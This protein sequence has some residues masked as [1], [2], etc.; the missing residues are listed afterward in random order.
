MFRAARAPEEQTS[1]FIASRDPAFRP[2][3]LEHGPDGALY[4]IDMQRDVIEHPDYIPARVREKLDIRA[5]QD[6]GRI[7]R[8]I[9]K[10]GLPKQ[11]QSLADLSSAQLVEL[12]SSSSPWHRTTAHKILFERRAADSLPLVL[13]DGLT[14]ESAA[15]RARSLW[16]V[17]ALGGKLE[18]VIDA[19]LSDPDPRV[20]QNGVLVAERHLPDRLAD[21]VVG[22]ADPHPQ[23]RFQ[24]ALSLDGV[25][26]ADG[27]QAEAK[28]WLIPQMLRR[29]W[30]SKWSRRAA[31][32]SIDSD[33]RQLLMDI[34]QSKQFQLQSDDPDT[35][36][37]IS[38]VADVAAATE[39]QDQEAFAR[40][41]RELSFADSQPEMV[42]ALMTGLE[43][44]WSR[45]SGGRLSKQQFASIANQ[46]AAGDID[47]FESQL[48]D[49]IALYEIDFPEPLTDLFVNAR[50][51][52]ADSQLEQL[53]RIAAIEILARDANQESFDLLI[54]LLSSP[55]PTDVQKVAIQS[56][57]QMRRIDTG[58]RLLGV[59][60]AML[61][62]IRSNVI[63][64][65]LSRREYQD[66]LLSALE[67][68]D[69]QF[70]ELNLDLEQRRRL[71]RWSTDEIGQRAAKLFGD[72]EYSNRKAVVDD[73]LA[74]LPPTGSI[75]EGRE[76]FAKKC[77]TCHIAE[78]KGNRV[79]PDL[80]ALS[81][82]S[83][84][85]LLTH[86]LDPN[87][88]INPNYV[89][90]VVQTVGR[91]GHQRFV[92]GRNH[93]LDHTKTGRRKNEDDLAS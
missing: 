84:E 21:L 91:P 56:I 12:L 42:S 44:G 63:Q 47:G 26:V 32:I 70:S 66:A 14:A 74:K 72:E 71:L 78:G 75:T 59:W 46:W 62:G 22:L 88:S 90:C 76:V 80:Q 10:D 37:L 64:L 83:V 16:L 30:Q 82:R 87:M 15:A 3:G 41:L 50:R 8:V 27:N 43:A 53:S 77:A 89:S 34:W 69:V 61:P 7:Y 54:D 48:I 86:I 35:I 40:W 81:H 45:R 33:A 23:V 92:G 6:R 93:R 65:L 57:G 68:G 19:S 25:Q 11:H 38:E 24:V 39:S 9:P 55:E 20:R 5:G 73:W 51:Q 31:L 17:H 49:L 4:L 13:A 1:E 28:R 79:G 52:V 60:S 18:S 85:D 29:D 58:Q 67:T 2:V 36:A